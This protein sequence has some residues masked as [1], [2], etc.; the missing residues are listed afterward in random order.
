MDGHPP[1]DSRIPIAAYFTFKIIPTIGAILS[2]YLGYRLF[3][4]GVTGQASLSLDSH[5]IRGQLLNAAPGLFFGVGGII[6]LIV[7]VWRGVDVSFDSSGNTKTPSRKTISRSGGGGGGGGS[8]RMRL[9]MKK[10]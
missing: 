5:S 9:M 3:V 2:I 7:A 4:L 10:K 6:V 8:R 1:I